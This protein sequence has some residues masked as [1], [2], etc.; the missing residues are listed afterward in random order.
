MTLKGFAKLVIFTAL[1]F[2]VQFLWPWRAIHHE[3]GVLVATVPLQ[4]EITPKALAEVAGWSLTAV[5]EYELKGRVL[6]TKRYHGGDN[7]G[8]VPVDVA[9]G[10]GRMSDE[11][12]LSQ[13]SISMGNRF[14]FYEWEEEPAIPLEEIKNSASNNHIIAANPQ[15]TSVVRWLRP[16]QVILFKGYLVNAKGPGGRTWNSSTRR[17]DDG[18]GACELFYVESARAVNSPGEL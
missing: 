3:P 10:W 13:F 16:G 6:G 5:A 14:F 15:V 9:V 7:A 2:S 8:L 1:V 18:N 17:E 12:V 11:S 4:K